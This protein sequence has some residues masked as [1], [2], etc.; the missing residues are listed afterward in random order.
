MAAALALCAWP[1]VPSACL[2]LSSEAAELGLPGGLVAIQV[3]IEPKS[4]SRHVSQSEAD[5]C[6]L[7]AKAVLTA[8]PGLWE[9]YG[10]GL[11]GLAVTTLPLPWPPP[12]CL[13]RL[14]AFGP[15]AHEVP[16]GGPRFHP[17]VPPEPCLSCPL[18]HSPEDFEGDTCSALL[19]ETSPGTTV[20]LE[21]T[22]SGL[23]PGC[24]SWSL[25]RWSVRLTLC[26]PLPAQALWRLQHF[27]S[28]WAPELLTVSG[29]AGLVYSRPQGTA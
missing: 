23:G 5:G 18:Q 19:T 8:A 24:G 15:R 16:G 11:P 29:S 2:A 9:V 20:G 4:P 1:C 27:S 12:H 14:C 17:G 6:P 26:A 25:S 21:L 22:D 13:H 7:W 28:I 10:H 3:D